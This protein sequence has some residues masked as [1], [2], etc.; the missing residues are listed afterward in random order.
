MHQNQAIHACKNLPPD[1]LI[2][3]IGMP[4]MNGLDLIEEARKINPGL[5]TVILSCHE[6]FQFAQRAVKL[7]VNDYIL[8]ETLRIDQ[9]VA[10]LR[11]LIKQL[12]EEEAMM[13]NLQ[14]L[15][16]V[17]F[18]SLSSVRTTFLRSLIDQ[19][20]WNET[21][22]LEKAE[23]SGIRLVKG[24]PYIPVLCMLERFSD[25]EKRFGGGHQLQFVID[26][27]LNESV[28]IEGSVVIT[29]NER[30][31]YVLYPYSKSIKRNTLEEINEELQNVQ[32]SINR[33]MKIGTSFYIGEV[34]DTM[35]V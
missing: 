27:A 23:N 18:H 5:K 25:V 32:K 34:C 1:I 15:Q 10:I 19:P 28:K 31:Y 17:V 11:E 33:Y 4:I 3:D 6:D 16:D 26:N 2:T 13:R 12:N 9:L 22:W 24:T 29:L 30:H 8:K 7:S 21:E 20:I 35:L 14:K